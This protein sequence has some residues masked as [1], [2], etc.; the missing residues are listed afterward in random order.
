MGNPTTIPSSTTYAAHK[1]NSKTLLIIGIAAISLAVLCCIC[2]LSAWI[3]G[4]FLPGAYQSGSSS[5]GRQPMLAIAIPRANQTTSAYLYIGDAEKDDWF[6]PGDAYYIE[7]AGADDTVYTISWQQVSGTNDRVD[8]E[9]LIRSSVN[10]TDPDRKRELILV[11]NAMAGIRSGML[12]FLE[13]ASD[14]FTSPLFEPSSDISPTELRSIYE[15]YDSVFEQEDA[16]L[17]AI[18][19]LEMRAENAAGITGCRR[20]CKPKAGIKESDIRVLF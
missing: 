13:A 9:S 14:G 18:V 2:F 11:A 10:E 16:T 5:S 15:N 19:A 8:L 17:N 20:V 7:A 6:L 3:I 12:A 1:S 4:N